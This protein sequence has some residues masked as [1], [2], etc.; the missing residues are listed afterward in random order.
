MRSGSTG[1]SSQERLLTY[2]DIDHDYTTT[3]VHALVSAAEN[4]HA[5]TVRLLLGWPEH[6]PRIGDVPGI[7][8]QLRA[9]RYKMYISL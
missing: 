9:L 2:D 7:G 1:R 5:S 3:L 6:A 4:G 8:L